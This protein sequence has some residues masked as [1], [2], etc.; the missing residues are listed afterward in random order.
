MLQS[1]MT[2]MTD[3]LQQ[4]STA[5]LQWK[6]KANNTTTTSSTNTTGPP[7]NISDLEQIINPQVG[8]ISSRPKKPLLIQPESDDEN[9]LD[10]DFDLSR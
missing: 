10:L 5:K 2:Q 1:L 6:W 3:F 4:N 8:R 7:P 9:Y